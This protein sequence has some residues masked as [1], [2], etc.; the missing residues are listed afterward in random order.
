M[1]IGMSSVEDNVAAT[2]Q[3]Y[4]ALDSTVKSV[5]NISKVN[6]QIEAATHSRISSVEDISVK[7][8]EI[9]NYTQQ[10]SITADQN[11]EASHDLDITSNNLKQLVK[12]FKI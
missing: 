7:L 8:R 2:Q 12:R 11:V 5:E 9:S 3:V 10:T 4:D 1:A 6:K